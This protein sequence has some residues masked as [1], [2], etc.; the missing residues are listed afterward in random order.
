MT[1]Y[2]KVG[3]WLMK[4]NRM[5]IWASCNYFSH[6]N[7]RVSNLLI[8]PGQ[9]TAYYKRDD[10]K[11]LFVNNEFYD[12]KHELSTRVIKHI[13][14][15]EHIRLFDP[16]YT[17]NEFSIQTWPSEWTLL[18]SVW[19]GSSLYKNTYENFFLVLK[20]KRTFNFMFDSEPELQQQNKK[21]ILC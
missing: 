13:N 17:D 11:Y 5:N 16:R 15:A 3:S 19:N 1:S 9:W 12:L 20:Y 7:V 8:K 21:S 4:S 2:V 6:D 14:N 18:T 10:R